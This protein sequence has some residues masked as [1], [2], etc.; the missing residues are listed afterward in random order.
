MLDLLGELYILIISQTWTWRENDLAYFMEKTN[1][2]P[3][4]NETKQKSPKPENPK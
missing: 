3:A 2:N 1:N 4:S